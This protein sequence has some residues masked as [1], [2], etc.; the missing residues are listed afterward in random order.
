M[1]I[2]FP[3]KLEAGR[4]A[5]GPMASTARDGGYGA[6]FVHGP[7]GEELKIIASGADADDKV[8]AGWEHVS[9]STRRPIQNWTEMCFVKNMFWEPTECV[10][11][12]HPPES[13]YVNNHPNCLHLW[14][15]TRVEFPLPPSILVGVKGLGVLSRDEAIEARR[16]MGLR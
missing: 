15:N 7:C 5:T 9:V 11:Q 14:R 13:E 10:V 16:A 12:F 2:K 4:V 3:D 8:S 1:R 6:F